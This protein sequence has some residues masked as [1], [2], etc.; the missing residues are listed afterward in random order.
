MGCTLGNV[1]NNRVLNQGLRSWSVFIPPF[2]ASS[3]SWSSLSLAHKC[4]V[5]PFL[6]NPF[7]GWRKTFS[8]YFRQRETVPALSLCLLLCKD[9]Y[10]LSLSAGK[11]AS[12]LVFHRKFL[13]FP[14]ILPLPQS[15]MK[16]QGKPSA[17]AEEEENQRA[18]ATE[19]INIQHLLPKESKSQRRPAA[20]GWLPKSDVSHEMTLPASP[21]LT[22][23]AMY[24]PYLI[25]ALVTELTY[26]AKR[27]HRISSRFNTLQKAKKKKK[28]LIKHPI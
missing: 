9:S 25:H 19:L 2:T 17:S 18:G 24:M 5:S 15:M 7:T 22:I 23:V 20:R 14:S 26:L 10:F 16:D 3:Q 27:C 6:L 11:S 28:R 8:D 21:Q 12:P 4:R 13:H 1:L